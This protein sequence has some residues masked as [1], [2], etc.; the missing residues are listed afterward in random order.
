MGR[1]ADPAGAYKV[2]PH[3]ANGYLYAATCSTVIRKDGTK[4]RKYTHLG[5]LEDG[6]RFVPNLRFI[7]MDAHE[8]EKLIFPAG[9]DLSAIE[10]R[11]GEDDQEADLVRPFDLE[12]KLYGNVWLLTKVAEATGVTRDL[13]IVLFHEREM[14]DDIL[15]LA[16]YAYL[17]GMSLTRLA[18]WQRSYKV[19]SNVDLTAERIS[20][21]TRLITHGQVME[22][23]GLRAERQG[24]GTFQARISTM[25]SPLSAH[26]F[27][28]D[29]E[30]TGVSSR[31]VVV[32][33]P[34]TRDPIYWRTLPEETPNSEC[35]RV[36]KEDLTNLGITDFYLVVD[37]DHASPEDIAELIIGQVPF[38]VLVDLESEPVVSALSRI[39]F[40]E[41]GLPKDMAYDLEEGLFHA[42]LPLEEWAYEDDGRKI[43]NADGGGLV[44]DAYLDAGRR[45]SGLA[46]LRMA[47][48][49]ERARLE[50]MGIDQ[51]LS[52]KGWLNDELR[53]HRV[54]YAKEDGMWSVERWDE[55]PER[56]ARAKA[57]CG[58]FASVAARV[59]GDAM[60][61]L[62]SLSLRDEQDCYFDQIGESLGFGTRGWTYGRERHGRMLIAFVGLI[63]GSQVSAT[64]RTSEDLRQKYPEAIETLDEMRDIRWCVGA[65]GTGNMTG[66]SNEQVAVCEAFGIGVPEHLA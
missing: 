46:E 39:A 43:T 49:D 37:S 38:V 22:F 48:R 35:V 57:V 32:Y 20:K 9:W 10:D 16:I 4:Y 12:N 63:L 30:E 56:V 13:M 64:W 52:A 36:I 55:C 66:M 54:S 58:F 19:P 15:T 23:F 34:D 11:E 33:A 25:R 44:L 26:M 7:T 3:R 5:A 31:E 60:E 27:E 8:R 51:M 59:E 50:S 47:V 42:Q 17:T 21:L 18:T 45:A 29:Y 62:A 2:M 61:H 14:V 53:F 1:K 41:D 28:N 65:D 40:D 24:Q 6:T